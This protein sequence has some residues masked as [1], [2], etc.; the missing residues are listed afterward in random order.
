[1]PAS[2]TGCGRRPGHLDIAHLLDQLVVH[3]PIVLRAEKLWHNDDII[4]L[5]LPAETRGEAE[6]ARWD[7]QEREEG[8]GGGAAQTV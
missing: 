2:V 6:Q 3:V 5:N 4:V 1:M 8:R 7:S